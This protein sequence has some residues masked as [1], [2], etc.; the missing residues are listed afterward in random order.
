MIG[1]LDLVADTLGSV[2]GG[3]HMEDDV[4]GAEVEEFLKFENHGNG[5]LD[6][7]GGVDGDGGMGGSSPRKDIG[8]M[9]P[10]YPWWHGVWSK[11]ERRRSSFSGNKG[12]MRQ[13]CEQFAMQGQAKH[14]SRYDGS[15]STKGMNKTQST[16]AGWWQ[17]SSKRTPVR[18]G[19]RGRLR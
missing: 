13:S 19:F 14:R 8:T 1:S 9:S 3:E 15:T 2:H 4:E 12:F 17:W 18:S 7:D 16:E 5:G 6:G 10:D 11:P